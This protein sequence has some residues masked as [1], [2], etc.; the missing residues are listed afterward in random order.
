M[1]RIGQ[2]GTL[3]S[4]WREQDRRRNIMSTVYGEQ[5]DLYSNLILSGSNYD[6]V[7]DHI[8]NHIKGYSNEA[9]GM[10]LLSWD[11]STW[12]FDTPDDKVFIDNNQKYFTNAN[13][14]AGT[15]VIMD[16]QSFTENLGFDWSNG[17]PYDVFD[18]EFNNIN[19]YDFIFSGVGDG[20]QDNIVVDLTK[21]D[22]AKWG[23]GTYTLREVAA[24]LLDPYNNGTARESVLAKDTLEILKRTMPQWANDKINALLS[25]YPENSKEYNELFKKIVVA[26]MD[27]EGY[28]AGNE[29]PDPGQSYLDDTDPTDHSKWTPDPKNSN[30]KS[31]QIGDYKVISDGENYG[32]TDKDGN[33][34]SFPASS[35]D[36]NKS[37]SENIKE[38]LSHTVIRNG[39]QCDV[40]K[41]IDKNGIEWTEYTPSGNIWKYDSNTGLSTS[42]ISG[43]AVGRPTEK[44][45]TINGLEVKSS[46]PILPN[47]DTTYTIT[48]EDGSTVSITA[49]QLEKSGMTLN[50]FVDS[51]KNQPVNLD[52]QKAYKWTSEVQVDPN[53]VLTSS[54]GECKVSVQSTQ[55]GDYK[56]YTDGKNY[57]FFKDGVYYSI[58]EAEY[59][60]SLSL[61]D[62]MKKMMEN[63]I[64]VNG[65]VCKPLPNNGKDSIQW[66]KANQDEWTFDPK[67]GMSTYKSIA[68][69]YS[70]P[71]YGATTVD[72]AYAIIDGLQVESRIESN[73]SIRDFKGFNGFTVTLSDGSTRSISAEQLEKSGMTLK[74]FVDS[75]KKQ[76]VFSSVTQ[77]TTSVSV[78]EYYVGDYKVTERSGSVRPQI[79]VTDKDGNEIATKYLD[80]LRKENMTVEQYVKSLSEIKTM[81]SVTQP[82]TSVSTKE[83]YVGDY[84]VTERSGSVRPQITVTDKDGNEIATVYQ[85]ELSAQG[86]SIE[87]YVK[88]MMLYA[89]HT[90]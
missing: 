14:E 60:K 83:Y 32:F 64:V 15:Y 23:A 65:K 73:G 46:T 12:N 56:V 45:A 24:N 8:E 58:S 2:T 13:L 54:W 28:T 37:L 10:D 27:N 7:L 31:C 72:T 49:E 4:E 20:R 67:T 82:T 80:E 29:L 36:S 63:T 88:V 78:R 90:V 26:L 85:D 3:G 87:D 18:L 84:K 50:E 44:F 68:D 35:I 39:Q 40:S 71:M 77:P 61:E 6:K 34:Y 76:P 57:S 47:P 55:V 70:V 43:L 19:F 79:T 21:F 11:D 89:S 41:S 33:Y 66:Y 1:V 25:Q 53:S 52:P 59:D 22:N 38:L 42:L 69:K 9:Q 5:M 74:E 16:E 51:I 81:A 30:V 86:L 75:I 17:K 62:N 48:K